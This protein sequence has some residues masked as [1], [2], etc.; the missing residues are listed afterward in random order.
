VTTLDTKTRETGRRLKAQAKR[1]RKQQRR[2][3]KRQDK[4]QDT[5]VYLDDLEPKQ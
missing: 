2:E 1:L 4:N 5:N 3:A